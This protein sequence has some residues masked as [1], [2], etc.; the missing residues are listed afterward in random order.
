MGNYSVVVLDFETTGLSPDLGDRTIEVGAVL[1]RENRIIDHLDPEVAGHLGV[2]KRPMVNPAALEL[3]E[4][5]QRFQA[6]AG[7]FRI[8]STRDKQ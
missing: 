1:I 8:E 3:F 2:G 6:V 4:T 7:G 5:Y